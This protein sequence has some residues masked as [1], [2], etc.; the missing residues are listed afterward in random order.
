MI[1][2]PVTVVIPVKNEERNLPSCLE[3][4]KDFSEVW[5]V[6][7]QSTDRTREIAETS[8]AKIVD[9]AWSGGFPKKRN[10]VLLNERFATPWVLF[11]DADEQVSAPFVEEL[12]STL[13]GTDKV[14]FWLNY[15]NYFLGRELRHGV[16]QRKLAL[17]RV[18]AGL[19]ERIEEQA[20]S[21]LDM[22]I[23]EHPVLNG[24]IGEIHER[25]DHRDFRGLDKFLLRHVDYAK[26]EAARFQALRAADP[27]RW[28]Q[29]TGRQRFKYRHLASWWYP[30]FYFLF[31]YVARLGFLD[32]RPGL[33][34]VYY[35]AWYFE[36]IRTLLLEHRILAG[37]APKN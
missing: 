10:W 12:R 2:I 18:G 33:L 13:P 26:W 29:L 17:F 22:E 19:Y 11:L 27:K 9:F 1:P 15:T 14:G 20:W 21:G 3:L 16:P 23:H 35:K 37:A 28:E 34:Y 32:R 24:P 6:D 36:T 5:I 25:I 4:L 30:W 8:G 7:S 31:A